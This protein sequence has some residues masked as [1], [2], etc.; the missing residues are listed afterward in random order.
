MLYVANGGTI[1]RSGITADLERACVEFHG[2]LADAERNDAWTK[3]TRGTRWNNEQLLLHMAFGYMLVQRLVFLVHLL[4]RLPEPVSRV[5]ARVLNAATTPFHPIN[6]YASCAAALVYNR[7]RM[8]AKLEGKRR[9]LASGHAFPN[10]MGPVLCGLHDA[11]RRLP[12]PR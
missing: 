1:D 3:P 9:S 5:Y 12:L 8:G 7:R 11:G 4:S 2:L 10:W 6:Y